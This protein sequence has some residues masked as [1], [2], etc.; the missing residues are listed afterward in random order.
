M[1]G[2]GRRRERVRP[3]REVSFAEKCGWGEVTDYELL[4]VF[5]VGELIA[6]LLDFGGCHG[7]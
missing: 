3:L 1:S 7:E 2:G 6:F 4:D 5:D